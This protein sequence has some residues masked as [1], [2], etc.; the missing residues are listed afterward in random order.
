MKVIWG[1]YAITPSA[2]PLNLICGLPDDRKVRVQKLGPPLEVIY[3]GT[4]SFLQQTIDDMPWRIVWVGPA[5]PQTSQLA[6]GPIVNY[7]ADPDLCR[8]AL[9]VA[10]AG[11]AKLQRPWF[12]HP[13]RIAGTT[14]DNVS[15]ILQGIQGLVVPK[16]AR[17]RPNSPADIMNA[18]EAGR[19]RYPVLVRSAGEHGGKTLIRIDEPIEQSFYSSITAD[20][21]LY[22]T[23]FY[24]FADDDGL[25][26]RYRF[27]VVGG[28]VLIKSVIM[29]TH[30]NLHGSSRT[31]NDR[32]IAQERDIIDG[33]ATSLAPRIAPAIAT[34][35]DRIGL[36][37][38]GID[39]AVRSDGSLL[40]FE[41][42]ANMDILVDIK[43]KPDLW[44]EGT[45]RIKAALLALL[46]NPE[47]WV[48]AR[49]TQ[50]IV[51]NA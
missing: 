37:Y 43:I 32:T 36:D 1:A 18:I 9:D 45:G 31:W 15:R 42:N 25:Y 28:D 8:I 20:R 29:G 46:R 33:F 23:E 10:R 40:V 17:C 39:C 24:D 22:I 16:V 44:S 50:P 48:A 7:I 11:A 38:F 4:A 27:A 51:V 12:N 30:W 41:V 13:D 35:Y 19:L 5:S 6:P 14:R 49:Q 47:R 21:D 2:R 34:I 26:R 3:D